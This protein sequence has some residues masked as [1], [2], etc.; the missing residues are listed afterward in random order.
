ME[1]VRAQSTTL[2]NLVVHLLTTQHPAWIQVCYSESYD[3][4]GG[5]TLIIKD[6]EEYD[7]SVNRGL[8]FSIV[9]YVSTEYRV[10]HELIRNDAYWSHY[11]S[12][13][14]YFVSITDADHCLNI[15]AYHVEN[16]FWYDKKFIHSILSIGEDVGLTQ[17]DSIKNLPIPATPADPNVDELPIP[18]Q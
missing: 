11:D 4:N 7:D 13:Y 12:R 18:K 6:G 17:F 14:E 9:S 5:V 8:H 1:P 10:K 2:R 3:E 15:Q 16:G